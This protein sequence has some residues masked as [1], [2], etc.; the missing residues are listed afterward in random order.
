MTYCVTCCTH[1]PGTWLSS[2]LSLHPDVEHTALMSGAARDTFSPSTTRN[3]GGPT[4]SLDPRSL[5]GAAHH[6]ALRQA[7]S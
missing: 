2:E 4:R 7:L 3:R 6:S 5:R 1:V